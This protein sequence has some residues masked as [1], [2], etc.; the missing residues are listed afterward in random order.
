[1]FADLGPLLVVG[2]L[3]WIRMVGARGVGILCL[4]LT[5]GEVEEMGA[6]ATCHEVFHAENCLESIVLLLAIPLL[7]T[8]P[9]MVVVVVVAVVDGAGY[10]I[11]DAWSATWTHLLKFVSSWSS[12]GAVGSEFLLFNYFKR[13]LQCGGYVWD[14][15]E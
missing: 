11:T 2:G 3:M 5:R 8:G 10:V 15:I 12:D 1:M 7:L 6:T 4:R 14:K 13:R 9:S